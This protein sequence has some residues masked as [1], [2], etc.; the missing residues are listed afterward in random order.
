M[1]MVAAGALVLGGATVASSRTLAPGGASVPA[2][3]VAPLPQRSHLDVDSLSEIVTDGDI[4]RLGRAPSSV[5]FGE[6]DRAQLLPPPKPPRPAPPIV[7]ALFGGPTWRAVLENVAGMER[8]V[9]V[10]KGM[11]AGPFQVV[12]ISGQSVR[13]TAGDTSWTLKLRGP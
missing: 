1:A 7:T 9:I 12:A 11:K 6:A 2:E 10:A 4:F 13:L 5:A 3:R 8:P